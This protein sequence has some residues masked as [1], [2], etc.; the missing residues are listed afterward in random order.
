MKCAQNNA[1]ENSVEQLT[2]RH[3]GIRILPQ[4]FIQH[5]IA[6]LVT[7]LVCRSAENCNE[8]TKDTIRLLL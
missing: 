5:S 6:D 7:N 8:H 4:M 1:M 3:F 2:A